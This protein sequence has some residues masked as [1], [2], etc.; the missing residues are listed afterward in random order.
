MEV[1]YITMFM[2]RSAFVSLFAVAALLCSPGP[3]AN[4]ALLSAGDIVKVIRQEPDGQRTFGGA[5]QGSDSLG[6]INS[7]LWGGGEF[8]LYRKVVS[9][10]TSTVE[11]EF[12]FRTFCLQINDVISMNEPVLVAG[13]S[14]RT[15]SKNDGANLIDSATD[16]LY[17]SYRS[18]DLATFGLGFI[19][20]N[21]D[22]A[23]AL[24]Q[25][26]WHIENGL[27]L[28]KISQKAKDLVQLAQ[29]M[30]EGFYPVQGVQALNLFIVSAGNLNNNTFVDQFDASDPATWPSMKAYYRQDV[31]FWEEPTIPDPGPLP[32]PEPGPTPAPIPEPGTLVLWGLMFGMVAVGQ[33]RW[34]R[35]K[36]SAAAHSM[37]G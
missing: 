11:W 17:S 31:L 2:S 21:D 29:D 15:V 8:A 3:Q 23:N 5:F 28:S 26:I 34:M 22:W 13:I 25:A 1:D 33:R 19:Y 9:G 30:T 24:Q 32:D 4:A 7:G 27:E 12:L 36:R 10:D 37:A 16:F 6:P 18:G 35:S 20:D 14:D